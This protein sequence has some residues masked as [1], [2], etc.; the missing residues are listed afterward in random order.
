MSTAQEPRAV[1]IKAAL[2]AGVPTG[3]VV[4]EVDEVPGSTGGPTGTPAARYV[5]FELG[6]RWHPERRGDADTVPG[7]SLTTH[8]RAPNVTDVRR[9]RDATTAALENRAYSLPDGDTVGPFSFQFDE[10]PEYVDG[11]WSAFDIW[12][13]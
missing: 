4:Y 2:V 9:G 3:W 6:R 10:Q 5:S 13:A 11:G 1:A 12:N 7:W 8:Y